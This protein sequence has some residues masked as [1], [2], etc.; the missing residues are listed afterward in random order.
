MFKFLRRLKAKRESKIQIRVDA[1]WGDGRCPMCGS[2]FYHTGRD[3]NNHFGFNCPDHECYNFV[4]LDREPSK[5][6]AERLS[7]L[8]M[9]RE[10]RYC[11]A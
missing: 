1:V 8:A 10:Q 9:R 3:A 2:R 7:R 4:V 6:K 11:N 5:H